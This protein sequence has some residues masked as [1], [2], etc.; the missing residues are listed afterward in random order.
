MKYDKGNIWNQNGVMRSFKIE[1]MN[2]GNAMNISTGIFTAPKAGIYHFSANFVKAHGSLTDNNPHLLVVLCVNGHTIAEANI[3]VAHVP[4]S[5]FASM[6]T[7]VKLR[8]GDRVNLSKNYGLL[9]GN[10]NSHSFSGWLV[11]EDL[12]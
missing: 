2:V 4:L 12:E 1:R 7:S 3:Y 5:A 9:E 11:E 8:K 10:T 6:E